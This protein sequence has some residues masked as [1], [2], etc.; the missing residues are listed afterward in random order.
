[1]KSQPKG[2]HPSII[3]H[4]FV[5]FAKIKADREINICSTFAHVMCATEIVNSFCFS[6]QN[7]RCVM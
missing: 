2:P 4:G 5:T 1:M 3:F 6:K 7:D